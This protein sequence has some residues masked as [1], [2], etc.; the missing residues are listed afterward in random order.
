M[1][2]PQQAGIRHWRTISK[3]KLKIMRKHTLQLHIIAIFWFLLPTVIVGRTMM[4]KNI[5][6]T[7]IVKQALS[8]VQ[9][10]DTTSFL[11]L[12]PSL[13]L[14]FKMDNWLLGPII[15]KVQTGIKMRAGKRRIVLM[16]FRNPIP[17]QI[18][19]IA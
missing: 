2:L 11:L 16:V 9:K 8:Q 12:L 17:S 4:K 15:Q 3:N 18:T 7:R 6:W 1:V 14:Q 13:H 5:S 10:N 19:T